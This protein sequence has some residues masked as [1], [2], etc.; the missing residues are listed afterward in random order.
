MKATG[1]IE[2]QFFVIDT[3]FTED[4]WIQAAEVKPSCRAVVHHVLV[5]AQPP[6]EPLVLDPDAF[7]PQTEARRRSGSGAARGGGRRAAGAAVSGAARPRGG[8][9]DGGFISKWL[10]ATVP[11]ARPMWLPEGMAKRVPAG[12]RLVIQIHYTATGA[13]QEDQCAIG[14][15]FADPKTVRKE[16]VTDMVVNPRFEIPPGDPSYKVEA[17]RVLEQDEEVLV[18][19][20]HTHVRGMASSTKPF[21]RMARRKFSWTCPHYDFNWQNSYVLAE[22]KLLPKGT[23]LHCEAGYN[24]SASNLANP[25]PTQTVRWGEQTWEEMM[26]GYY[27]RVLANE[28]RIKNPVAAAKAHAPKTLPK[29]DANLAKLAHAALDSQPAF[30]AFAKAV[31]EKLPQV[32]RV[33]VTSVHD[34]NYLVQRSAYPGKKVSKFAETGFKA[35]SRMV[36][37]TGFALFNGCDPKKG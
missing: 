5:F 22:P 15:V 25:D 14:L 32:D 24:N 37:L 10:T 4:K 31:H 9:G 26:I 17:E 7:N 13:P 12:S 36:P 30:D 8:N 20:P 23:T 28:D 34:G 27:D 11:G 3:G 29:L 19:M 1:A 33:C 16:V 35:P 2:Y 21:T 18:L 6:S